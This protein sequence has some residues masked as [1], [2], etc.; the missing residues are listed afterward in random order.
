MEQLAPAP[1]A[2]DELLLAGAGASLVLMARGRGMRFR[3]LWPRGAGV[4]ASRS[5]TMRRIRVTV[6]GE[7]GTEGPM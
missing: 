2:T 3:S 4:V 1:C 5:R 7:G 6:A